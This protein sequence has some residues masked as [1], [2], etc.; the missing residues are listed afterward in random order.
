MTEKLHRSYN[1]EKTKGTDGVT[2]S[3]SLSFWEDSPVSPL[4][5]GDE[6]QPVPGGP[7][8]KVSKVGI[9]DSVVGE[10]FGRPFRQ[11][12]ITIEGDS[13]VSVG[14]DTGVKY[15]FSIEK[16]DTGLV[17]KNGTMEVT[18]DGDA[19]ALN[20]A[21][22]A[23][24]SVPGIGAVVCTKINGGDSQ[25][26]DGTKRW[27]VTYDGAKVD[28]SSGTGKPEDTDSVSYEL[29]GVTA[30]SVSGEFIALRRSASAVIKKSLTLYTAGAAPLSTPGG[31]Y[32]GGIATSEKVTKESVKVG[33]VEVGVYYRHDIEVES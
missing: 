32:S 14:D 12:Q 22:G 7:K 19:P 5:I 11:W 26:S 29:N 24:F 9:A 16:Q 25:K 8:L 3:G 13:S 4:D 18:N 33:G 27:A 31:G 2:T 21:I 6:F 23:L 30:R 10:R 20:I 15:T 28:T 1:L 17:I